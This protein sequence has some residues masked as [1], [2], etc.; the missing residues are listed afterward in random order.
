LGLTF[1]GLTSEYRV[2][3][4]SQIHEIV[5]YGRGGYDYD[6]VYNM[7]IWLRIFTFKKINEHYQKE[8]EEYDKA[9]DKSSNKQTIIGEDG[10]VNIPSH[11]EKSKTSY[12]V[13]TSK[14]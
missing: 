3:L 6:T 11:M 7:P 1:F 12:N 14:K 9:K 5:F 10:K 4:F 13:G 8:K 2:S